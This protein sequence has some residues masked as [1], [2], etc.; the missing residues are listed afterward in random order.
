MALDTI[1]NSLWRWSLATLIGIIGTLIGIIFWALHEK[2]DSTKENIEGQIENYKKEVSGNL[3]GYREI[4][5]GEFMK[6]DRDHLEFW[7][8]HKEAREDREE[9]CISRIEHEKDIKT[10]V[11]NLTEVKGNQ[12]L[13]IN[14]LQE[15]TIKVTTHM[16]KDSKN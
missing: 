5:N 15:L 10:I 12:K 16:A 2:I 6:N 3:K 9:R 8:L 14:T 1:D 7:K 4:V 13:V 11:E